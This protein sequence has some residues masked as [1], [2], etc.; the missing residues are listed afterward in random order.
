[1]KARGYISAPSLFV[2]KEFFHKI[3]N[4]DTPGCDIIIEIIISEEIG[5]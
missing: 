4:D 2:L 3:V 5:E 1:M